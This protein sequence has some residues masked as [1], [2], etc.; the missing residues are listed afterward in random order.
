M[1]TR[2]QLCGFNLLLHV[3]LRCAPASR[4]FR[5]MAAVS[6]TGWPFKID[7]TSHMEVLVSMDIGQQKPDARKYISPR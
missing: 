3:G 7:Q 1:F 4:E 5:Q 2:H 6:S